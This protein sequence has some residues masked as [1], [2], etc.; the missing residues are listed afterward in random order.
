MN[1]LPANPNLE[2]DPIA[3]QIYD[4][5]GNPVTSLGGGG[6]GSVDLVGL[7]RIIGEQVKVARE[8]IVPENLIEA[9]GRVVSNDSISPELQAALL[10]ANPPAS[11]FV[12]RRK[13]LPRS[14]DQVYNVGYIDGKWVAVTRWG[15]V[16]QY[17]IFTSPDGINWTQQRNVYAETSSYSSQFFDF[18]VFDG[19][20]W[21]IAQSGSRCTIFSSANGV[22]W[23]LTNSAGPIN[24]T[25]AQLFY[26]VRS[27]VLNGKIVNVGSVSTATTSNDY[28]SF[29]NDGVAWQGGRMAI[30]SARMYGASYAN[31]DGQDVYVAVGYNGRLQTSPDLINWTERT[32]GVSETLYAVEFFAGR[33]VAFGSSGRVISSPDGIN[34]TREKSINGV[35]TPVK[36]VVL[37]GDEVIVLIASSS[38]LDDNR[39]IVKSSDLVNWSDERVG[40][41]RAEEGGTTGVPYAI[42][43]E[44]GVI[45]VGTSLGIGITEGGPQVDPLTE[46]WIP[47][48][49]SDPYSKVYL[50]D[51]ILV[52]EE[53]A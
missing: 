26:P 21:G 25:G 49:E 2:R 19:K 32:S 4:Q 17:Y 43:Q 52:E 24:P 5:N 38:A 7:G 16:S 51:R 39:K 1:V 20:L 11:N 41:K 42:W 40:N 45:A 31:I 47:K 30:P 33:F 48:I 18:Y 44:N 29:S 37:P 36:A 27:K 53:E 10:R 34:W 15:N 50:V 28:I 12:E 46:T 14:G 13:D 9:N 3:V 23:T 35:T 22:D 6:A 8:A